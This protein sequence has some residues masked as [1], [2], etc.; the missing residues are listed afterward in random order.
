MA[1]ELGPVPTH[2][3]YFEAIEE[4]FIRLR[5]A[6]LLLSPADWRLTERWRQEGVP[7]FVVLESLREVFARR[8]ERAAA[9]PEG[10]RRRVSSLRYCRRAVEKAWIEHRE[11]GGEPTVRR[12]SDAVDVKARL[13]ALAAAL[14]STLTE[15]DSWRERLLELT[16]AAPAVEDRLIELDAELGEAA[17]AALSAADRSALS[18]EADRVL[19]RMAEQVTGDRLA[20]IRRRLIR[21]LV[22]ERSGLPL[23][24]LFV[25]QDRSG[26]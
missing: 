23:L 9:D 14:P 2:R 17:L 22:R 11:L 19:A 8:A 18:G 26:R 25:P 4:E 3:G 12:G 15:V 10:S 21:R 24:S 13:E 1:R 7:L 6:P 5:G 20:D 16:G